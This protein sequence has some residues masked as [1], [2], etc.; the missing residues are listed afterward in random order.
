MGNNVEYLVVAGGGGG[1]GSNGISGGAG[2]GGLRTNVPGVVDGSNSLGSS[3]PAPQ[4]GGDGSGN[5]TVTV[6]GGGAA[7][8]ANDRYT[9]GQGSNS[10]LVHH[11]HQMV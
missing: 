1:S 9:G 4:T 8:N 2:A 6:G 11:Q 10:V 7:G 3:V 5:Y